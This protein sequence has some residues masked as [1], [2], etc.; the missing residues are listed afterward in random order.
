MRIAASEAWRLGAFTCADAIVLGSRYFETNTSPHRFTETRAEV[1]HQGVWA[2]TARAMQ[3]S[4]VPRENWR[5]FYEKIENA[6]PAIFLPASDD[7]TYTYRAFPDL[8]IARQP[9]TVGDMLHPHFIEEYGGGMR[10][11]VYAASAH[12]IAMEKSEYETRLARVAAAVEGMQHFIA[13][14]II[15]GVEQFNRSVER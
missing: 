11:T 13:E 5:H 10:E 6:S 4:P 14:Q 9:I 1:L 7:S 2:G 3:S 15:P 8:Q 12:N